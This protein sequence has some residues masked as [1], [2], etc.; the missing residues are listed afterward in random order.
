MEKLRDSGSRS[1]LTLY[2]LPFI[3]LPPRVSNMAFKQKKL[4]RNK[5]DLDKGTISQMIK[6]GSTRITYET[7]KSKESNYQCFVRFV[8]DDLDSNFVICKSCNNFELIKYIS[9]TGTSVIAR[10][11]DNF[12]NVRGS[13]SEHEIIV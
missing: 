11:V 7:L 13:G 9:S 5:I 8:V 12:T 1:R 4:K 10:H 2:S 3:L 6:D